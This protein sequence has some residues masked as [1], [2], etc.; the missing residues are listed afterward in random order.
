MIFYRKYL[1]ILELRP[2]ISWFYIL[3]HQVS[4]GDFI[5]LP[6]TANPATALVFNYGD[7]YHLSNSHYQ[8]ELLPRHF[9]SGVSTEPYKISLSGRT[10]SLGVIFRTNTFRKICRL[11][12]PETYLDKRLDAELLLGKKMDGF[13]DALAAAPTPDD[14]IRLANRFFLNLFKPILQELT[15]ADHIM[16]TIL[17]ARGLL[18]MDDLSAKFH[19]S[20]RH[21]RRLFSGHNGL[22]PKFYARLKRFGYARYRFGSADFNWRELLTANGFYDQAHLIKEFRMFSGTLPK[23]HRQVIEKFD[24]QEEE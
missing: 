11:A 23:L 8:H 17:D 1:P 21:L 10:G 20:P 3:E 15:T 9:F 22:S 2:H 14:K 12:D 13:P 18:D 19:I 5:E 4:G 7:R 6:A 16:G 24:Y